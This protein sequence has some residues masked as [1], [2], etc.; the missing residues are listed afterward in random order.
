MDNKLKVQQTMKLL[1]QYKQ[2]HPENLFPDGKVFR[3]DLWIEY[4]K[5]HSK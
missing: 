5:E 1:K 2:E 4:L 3:R